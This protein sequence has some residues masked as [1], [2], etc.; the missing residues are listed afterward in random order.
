[1]RTNLMYK[2]DSNIRNY[3]IIAVVISIVITSFEIIPYLMM[4]PAIPDLPLNTLFLVTTWIMTFTSI[5]CAFGVN[6]Y[7]LKPFNK[8]NPV[9][10]SMVFLAFIIALFVV[11]F[12][13]FISGFYSRSVVREFIRPDMNFSRQSLRFTIPRGIFTGLVTTLYTFFTK[14]NFQKQ[15]F[16]LEN[17]MLKK[18]SIKSQYEALKNEISPHFLFNSLNALQSIIREDSKAAIDYV[19]HLSS[20]LRYTIQDSENQFVDLKDELEL[21]ESYIYLLKMRFGNNLV[22][23]ISIPE[24]SQ[25]RKVLPLTIQTLVENAIKHNEISS[26][27]PLKVSISMED[28]LLVVAN[29]IQDKLTKE[30]S[31]GIGLS[32]LEQ[33]YKLLTGKEIFIIRTKTQFIVKVPAI[34]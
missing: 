16:E 6:Y 7:I 23:N 15:S 30:S 31:M 28:D 1:M 10:G 24:I 5:L 25:S 4:R 18:E 19:R 29:D 21:A 13:G 32:N 34:D 14:L 17:E 11:I 26:R 3:I 2:I 33:R 20:V 8:K 22:I 12:F 9:R 27:S